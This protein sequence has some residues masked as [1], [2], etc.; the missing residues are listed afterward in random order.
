MKAT[1]SQ[2][3]SARV[4]QRPALPEPLHSSSAAGNSQPH[5]PLKVSAFG[6]VSWPSVL[7]SPG[8]ARFARRIF[9]PRS[10]LRLA[11]SDFQLLVLL[12]QCVPFLS[13][14]CPG[15]LSSIHTPRDRYLCRACALSRYARR[16]GWSQSQLNHRYP[17][18]SPEGPSYVFPHFG[19]NRPRVPPRN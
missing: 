18:V 2:R 3:H 6:F 11:T 17:S 4:G 13:S 5:H 9:R 10:Q 15:I 12:S 16:I 19:C 8:W 1:K 7:Q 14:L